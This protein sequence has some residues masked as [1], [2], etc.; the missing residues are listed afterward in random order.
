MIKERVL[1]S[2]NGKIFVRVGNNRENMN[3]LTMRL[4]G[5]IFALCVITYI[6]FIYI[7]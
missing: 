1:V 4:R 6:F 2:I 3:D 7:H 5:Y